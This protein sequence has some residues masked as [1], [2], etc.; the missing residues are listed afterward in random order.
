MPTARLKEHDLKC[1]PEYFSAHLTGRKNFEIR[2]AADGT[3]RVGDILV[4]WEFEPCRICGGSGRRQDAGRQARC[5]CLSGVQPQGGY[6]GRCVQ[7]L[8]TYITALGQ[9]DGQ[10]V[11]GLAEWRGA[12]ESGRPCPSAGRVRAIAG[13][14]RLD[15]AYTQAEEIEALSAEL[16]RER[17]ARELLRQ[18]VLALR[19]AVATGAQDPKAL[20][21]ETV[22][23]V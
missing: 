15:G 23:V 18:E 4:L 2:G 8:V 12:E 21:D 17:E 16:Q 13:Q 20:I 14:L 9:A 7:R 22:L 3:F 19:P 11:M 6:T 10:V 1:W 5:E